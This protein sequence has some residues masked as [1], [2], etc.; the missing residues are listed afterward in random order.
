MYARISLVNISVLY[1]KNELELYYAKL[2]LNEHEFM[3]LKRS[4]YKLEEKYVNI[5]RNIFCEIHVSIDFFI[6]A[7]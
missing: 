7:S 4:C 6:V 5:Y 1:K 2:L 3:K